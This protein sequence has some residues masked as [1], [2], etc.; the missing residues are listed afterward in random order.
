MGFGTR[1]ILPK[2]TG[3]IG[4]FCGTSRVMRVNEW[5]DKGS[6]FGVS[7]STGEHK[8]FR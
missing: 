6:P 8:Y 5:I 4:S 1:G 2:E 3:F 7:S